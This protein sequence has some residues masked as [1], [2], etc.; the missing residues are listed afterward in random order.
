MSAGF[1]EFLQVF[2]T[3]SCL[4]LVRFLLSVFLLGLGEVGLVTQL[5]LGRGS[6]CGSYPHAFPIGVSSSQAVFHLSTSLMFSRV[7]LPKGDLCIAH[8]LVCV[9]MY[10]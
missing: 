7:S 3:R 2:Q 1:L 9:L 5:A 8:I 10:M 4:L 6:V